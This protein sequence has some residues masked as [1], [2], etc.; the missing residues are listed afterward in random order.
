MRDLYNKQLEKLR[1]DLTLMGALCEDII[2][3]VINGLTT[4]DPEL[5][6]KT[7]VLE[8][9]I[10]KKEREIGRLCVMLLIRE[11]P[12][13]R[14]L[15]FITTCQKM[16]NDMERIGDNA[17]SIALLFQEANDEQ[18]SFVGKYMEEMAQ[19]VSKILSDAVDCF[20][21]NNVDEARNVILF[22]IVINNQFKNIKQDIIKRINERGE[23]GEVC[24][25][26]FMTAKYLERIGD[27]AKNI[28]KLVA[29]SVGEE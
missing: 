29:Y 23:H 17:F 19:S 24:L 7:S 3:C 5:R 11:Q 15:R 10:D 14:D 21:K 8:D 22:D 20:I 27:H 9:E 12:V 1:N 13:A 25:D 28:A 4:N 16:I 18:R 26:I 2:D 6:N